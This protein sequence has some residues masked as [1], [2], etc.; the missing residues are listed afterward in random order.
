MHSSVLRSS[1]FELFVKGSPQNHEDF[2]KG[3]ANTRRL[4]FIAENGIE[5]IGAV[6]LVM[7]HATAFYNAY[8]A[9]KE[10]F[11]AYPDFF[12]FQ[13][14]SPKVSYSML[15]IHPDNK[16]VDIGDDP[17]D[18][19]DA[20]NDRGVNVLVVPDGV[21]KD[22]EFHKIQMASA[23]RNIDTCYVYSSKG[24]VSNAD[25][26]IRCPDKPLYNE[27]IRWINKVFDSVESEEKAEIQEIKSAWADNLNNSY[28]EQS[29]RAVSLDE[30]LSLL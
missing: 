13:H 22:S 19:L 21:K 15:D 14:N 10:E 18:R 26:I 17:Q 20:I 3:W 28:L 30:A 24:V 5:G 23:K 6:N 12:S 16:H 25:L 11:F 2:F 27:Y 1:D 9:T 8:R 7:A 29:F 4:G